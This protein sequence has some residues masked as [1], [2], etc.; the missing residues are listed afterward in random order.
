[1]K[2]ILEILKQIWHII[3]SFIQWTKRFYF[4]HFLIVY[5]L[6]SN[7]LIIVAIL[8]TPI[9]IMV[10]PE[11]KNLVLIGAS[12]FAMFLES[13]FAIVFGVIFQLVAMIVKLGLKHTIFVTSNFLLNN[14]IY[15]K[16]YYCSIILIVVLWL[17]SIFLFKVI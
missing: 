17:L 6:P 4:F 16:F 10:T 1:M 14:K 3:C 7:W 15:D 8:I 13:F 9:H 2:K 5:L 12:L 11:G